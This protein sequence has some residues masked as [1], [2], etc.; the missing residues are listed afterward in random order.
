MPDSGPQT[1]EASGCQDFRGTNVTTGKRRVSGGEFG[2]L[3]VMRG[4]IERSD[5]CRFGARA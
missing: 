1:E 4:R 3:A 5:K 2:V